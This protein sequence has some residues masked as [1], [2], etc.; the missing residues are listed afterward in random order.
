[1][2]AMKGSRDSAMPEHGTAATIPRIV[3][4]TL[5]I[6][7]VLLG[8]VRPA[9]AVPWY[10]EPPPRPWPSRVYAALSQAQCEAQLEARRIPFTR[11]PPTRG[12]RAPVRMTGPLR[13]VHFRSR[14][15]EEARRTS[16]Y[17]IADCRLVLALDDLA[18]ILARNGVTE[19]RHYSM[20]RPPPKSFPDGKEGKRHK[21]GLAID[22]GW[23]KMA[24]GSRID[25]YDDWH[26]RRGSRACGP[27]ARAPR[28][29]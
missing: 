12:V 6:G 22:F 13:G 23:M 24:D 18:V 25:V 19:V 26:G 9:E 17:E 28:P 2:W 7:L 29:A 21:G 11:E 3:R 20:Y 27:K 14:L 1:M 5:V 8:A 10:V 16:V 15:S 4:R